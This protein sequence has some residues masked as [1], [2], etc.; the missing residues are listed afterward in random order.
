MNNMRKLTVI[1][2]LLIN[3]SVFAQNEKIDSLENLLQQNQS[4][5]NQLEILGQLFIYYKDST[6]MIQYANQAIEL[7]QKTSNFKT[8][9]KIYRRLSAI[10]PNLNDTETAL[11]YAEKALQL[12]NKLEDTEKVKNLVAKSKIY[13]A[14]LKQTNKAKEELLKALAINKSLPDEKKYPKGYLDLGTV[15]WTGGDMDNARENYEEAL[16]LEKLQKGDIAPALICMGNLNDRQGNLVAA[17]EYYI[18]ALVL[19]KNEN[20][21]NLHITLN[22]ISGLYRYLTE[23]EKSLEYAEKMLHFSL[24]SK[25]PQ[26]ILEA[27]I[28]L[29]SSY[30][31][32][33]DYDSAKKYLY[34]AVDIAEKL[35]RP[36]LIAKSYLRVASI[37]STSETL[38]DS[39][40]YYGLKTQ[41]IIEENGLEHFFEETLNSTLGFAYLDKG[42]YDKAEF[43][44]KKSLVIANETEDAFLIANS[45]KNLF[46][47]YEKQ[48]KSVKALFHLKKFNEL[49]DS[50]RSKNQSEQIAEI[51]TKY[52]TDK[53]EAE[54]KTLLATNQFIAKQNQQY[55]I[56]ASI[57]TG[58]LAL[59]SYFFFQLRKTRNQLTA[60]NQ[61]LKDLNATKDKFFGI[62]AHDI[63]SPITA[64]DGV[65]EQMN[66]YLEK[67]DKAK[68]NRLADRIDTTAKRLTSLLDN[69]LN[70]ALLQTGMIPYN[71]KSVNIQTI[72]QE[73]ID[74]FQPIA[75]AKNIVLNNKISTVSPVFSDESA[76]QTI[77][78][79]LVNNAIK[80]TPAG[81]EVSISS[82][83]KG[84]KIF[85][86]INDTGTGI[87]ADKLEK[88][89]SLDK[90]SSK[91]TAG[92]KGSGLGLMLCKE[93]VELN[94]GTI[95]A[96]SELGKGSSFILSLP[97]T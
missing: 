54:N 13:R 67:D 26:R 73:N 58:V 50:L 96:I 33:D 66:Y 6:K 49:N 93:L 77:I 28:R 11:T 35:G 53:K 48:G 10:Y 41:Q 86:K 57:L 70:W 74:L 30:G 21:R 8:E 4:D 78:R 80:F 61:Q 56:G 43:Y 32:I 91:G 38:P 94:K 19:L 87:A 83:E 75:E 5:A 88:L 15:Y 81:G 92:E 62:I 59:L 76:L 17:I 25:D 3:I 2:L 31:D 68:L 95:Q 44:H 46:E 47:L 60:Q 71:P 65:S 97:R 27:N 42:Q 9:A 52:E 69:L 55:K 85:I 24:L 12:S 63:R 7:A 82:E 79:N 36:H 29:G 40:I 51:Q 39:A 1:L 90:Q 20:K 84:D 64:L 14:H 45:E 18:E 37:Y 22:N 89:F 34:K 16:R 23:Y 72:A